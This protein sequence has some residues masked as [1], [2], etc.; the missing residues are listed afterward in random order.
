MKNLI[1]Y[2]KVEHL[3]VKTD[4]KKRKNTLQFINNLMKLSHE[5]DCYYY[6][7]SFLPWAMFL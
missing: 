1:Y 4:K 3:T 2:Y 7:F 5:L 6:Y